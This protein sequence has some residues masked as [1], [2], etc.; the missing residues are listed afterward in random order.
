MQEPK[1]TEPRKSLREEVLEAA[2]HLKTFAPQGEMLS[3]SEIEKLT[4]LLLACSGKEISCHQGRVVV[5][6]TED[7]TRTPKDSVQIEFRDGDKLFYRTFPKERI[8]AARALFLGAEVEYK[9]YALG[10]ICASTL[11]YV[12]PTLKELTRRP[13]DFISALSDEET[14]RLDS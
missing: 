2:A 7:R 4:L 6:G 12:G 10:T 3:E 8:G 9:I 5:I 11:R 1:K 13:A 14:K